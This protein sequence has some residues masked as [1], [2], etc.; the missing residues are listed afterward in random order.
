MKFFW[1]ANFCPAL[2]GYVCTF[3]IWVLANWAYCRT[4]KHLI[5][6]CTKF[7]HLIGQYQWQSEHS[8]CSCASNVTSAWLAWKFV[9]GLNNYAKSIQKNPSSENKFTIKILFQASQ[10][11][12]QL[13]VFT[14]IGFYL[15][16]FIGIEMLTHQK[17]MHR[18]TDVQF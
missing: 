7:C 16:V 5:G 6:C 4:R 2:E 10:A 1:I 18:I 11:G 8:Q 9:R 17:T 12:V 14:V 13:C 15:Y 3:E